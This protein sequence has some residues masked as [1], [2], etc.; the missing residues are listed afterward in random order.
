MV[1]PTTATSDAPIDRAQGRN[2][3]QPLAH[4]DYVG[5]SQPAARRKPA[6]AS[7]PDTAFV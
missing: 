4:A 3:P 5:R 7:S 6:I 2:V 1:R